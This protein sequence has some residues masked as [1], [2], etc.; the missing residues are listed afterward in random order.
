[1]SLIKFRTNALFINLK[2]VLTKN[3]K[4]YILIRKWSKPDRV[5]DH[6]TWSINS[7]AYPGHQNFITLVRKEMEDS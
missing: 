6:K 2:N 5:T 7:L 4:I 3:N 1:M